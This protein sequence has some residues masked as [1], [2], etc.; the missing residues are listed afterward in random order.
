MLGRIGDLSREGRM[1]GV[2]IAVEDAVGIV[3]LGLMP[4]KHHRVT[5]R[6]DSRVVVVAIL[7]GGD[8]VAQ[9]RQRQVEDARSTGSQGREVAAA[10]QRDHP[11]LA[12]RAGGAHEFGT[13]AVLRP[14][15]GLEGHRKGLEGHRI[16]GDLARV[17]RGRR[18]EAD[19]GKRRSHPLGR[20]VETLGA[21]PAALEGG[22]GEKLDRLAEPFLGDLGDSRRRGRHGGSKPAATCHQRR[23]Q[24]GGAEL[25]RAGAS[26]T[27]IIASPAARGAAVASGP[28]ILHYTQED[29]LRRTT[30]GNPR[31]A[32]A[33][34]H[35]GPQ[36][37]HAV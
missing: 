23:S 6:V 28:R 14:E 3:L 15:S 10:L 30:P 16:V 35:P 2:L 24:S 37:G 1:A 27:S 31:R 9:K 34:C 26:H 21:R 32:I 33:V 4:Q 7:G 18:A 17:G 36:Q 20:P 22:R 12:V 13:V 11:G 25:A 19:L 8:A 5:G 29:S